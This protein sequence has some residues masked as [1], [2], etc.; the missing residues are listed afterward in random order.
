MKYIYIRKNL[1]NGKC[2][3][4][5]TKSIIR[6]NSNWKHEKIYGNQIITKD[7]DLYGF[8]SF[9]LAI[10]KECDDYESDKWEDYYIKQYNTLFP[11]GYN[12]KNGGISGWHHSEESRRKISSSRMG[13]RKGIP[14]TEEVKKKI[15]EAL[16]GRK[17]SSGMT[18]HKHSKE[19][20]KKMSVSHMKQV[21]Q[22]TLDGKLVR[23]WKSTL[24]C[25]YNGF[26][27]SHVA[28][29]CRGDEKKHKGFRWSYKPL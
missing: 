15:S 6:R 10:L 8:D 9:E 5:Q 13:I 4:G 28:A 17:L 3:I 24:E 18:G 23:I 19:S 20:K 26:N 25:A 7:R 11:N 29:C 2:Y 21:Y 14:I 12:I 22:Y 1:I 16:K 27:Q